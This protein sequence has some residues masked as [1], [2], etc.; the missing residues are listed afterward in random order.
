MKNILL[1]ISIIFLINCNRPI[2]SDDV[3][4]FTNL[5]FTIDENEATSTALIVTGSVINTGTI[6][7]SSPLVY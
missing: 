6:K 7:V 1:I 4:E 5:E 2:G 3:I